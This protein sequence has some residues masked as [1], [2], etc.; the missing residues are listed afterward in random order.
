MNQLT[1]YAPAS[2]GNVSVGFDLLGAALAPI[3]GSLLGDV[4]HLEAIESG[5][6]VESRGRFADKLP[7]DPKQN[8]IYDC[9]WG[10]AEALQG[11]GQTVRPA[12]LILEKNLPI[13]SGLGSSAASIVAA[14]KGL[15]E[16]H[17]APF[18]EQSLL[19]LMGKL[20]GQISGSIHYD[21]VAPCALGG[22]QLMVEQEAI[23]SQAI[24]HF[25]NWYWVV[26][27]PGISISTSEA[28]AILP[29]Q[30]RRSDLISFGKHLAGFIHASYSKQPEL[31]ASLLTDVVAEPYRASLIPGFK[32]ARQLSIDSGAL[33]MGISGSGPT[34]FM[35]SDDLAQANRLARWLGDNFIQ[36]SDGF[37][38]VCK[39]DAQGARVLSA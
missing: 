9:Y 10:F 30:Y 35:V 34:L 4:L 17:G 33:A 27:Y 38:H 25:E 1:A 15:N 7:K 19:R 5:V 6:E 29:G 11:M 2:I 3:D 14:L 39:L 31:A 28:R 23:I 16:W 12:R 20:E 36:N 8:I 26:A 32:A 24:P 22:L 21:N 13:G 18:D 37:V